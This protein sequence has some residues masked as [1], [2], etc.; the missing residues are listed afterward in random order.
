MDNHTAVA[1]KRGQRVGTAIVDQ[2][3]PVAIGSH[4]SFRSE[5]CQSLAV[6][7]SPVTRLQ[8]CGTELAREGNEAVALHQV[9]GRVVADQRVLG[10]DP[11]VQSHD[12]GVV[13]PVCGNDCHPPS[14]S[15]EG[16]IPFCEVDY[17]IPDSL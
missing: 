4:E 2:A 7:L 12:A 3:V 13:K 8:L 17:T 10:R 5:I 6:F 16:D 15:L 11:A 9:L 14:I 1:A